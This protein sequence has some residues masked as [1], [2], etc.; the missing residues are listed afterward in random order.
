MNLTGIGE[1][2]IIKKPRFA[3]KTELTDDRCGKFVEGC[4]Y[5]C[6]PIELRFGRGH[7]DFPMFSLIRLGDITKNSQ[8]IDTS[9][10]SCNN[11]TKMQ[12]ELVDQLISIRPSALDVSVS[13]HHHAQV[14]T[15]CSPRCQ[16]QK[17]E[18]KRFDLSKV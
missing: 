13:M 4:K 1:S 3:E 17:R 9:A 10:R 2:K 11:Y 18:N 15:C 5:Y 6:M 14:N 7:N 8:L 12:L 16:M